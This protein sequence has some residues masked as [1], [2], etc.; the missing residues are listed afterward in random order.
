MIKNT[1]RFLARMGARGCVGQALWD[2][3]E[4]IEFFY[5]SAD[6]A[7]ASGYDR[8]LNKY[9]E[10]FLDTGIAEQ[11]LIGVA[12]G[13]AADGTPV[14]ATTWAMF[15]SARVADQVR[16]F[17]GYMQRNIKLIG[18]DSGLIQSRFSYSHTNPPD[19][20][21]MRAIPG[22]TIISPCDGVEIYTAVQ[23]ALKIRGPVY[24]RLTGGTLL[25][26]IH[27]SDM[28]DF[29]IG[30]AITLK[31]GKRV[32]IIGCGTILE[33]A[34][35]AAEMLSKED[36]D[37]A[38]I[39]MHTICP[40]DASLLDKLIDYELIVSLEEHL[41]SGG[42]GSAIAEYYSK[43]RT[44]PKQIMMGIDNKYT[45]P[46]S[47]TYSREQNNLLSEQIATRIISELQ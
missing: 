8:L 41:L 44:S 7:H 28:I 32:A 25:P 4:E 10:R 15:A 26:I 36:I 20:A 24:I 27:N 30:K 19:I 43:Y 9:P 33:N 34:L 21:I 46:G 29:H 40:I 3:A 38:V 45:E 39:D 31:T 18:M 14:V 12:A 1:K 22:I 42:L 11:N 17:M 16:N 2:C 5:T 13:L 6:L 47:E 23:A 37:C 35:K